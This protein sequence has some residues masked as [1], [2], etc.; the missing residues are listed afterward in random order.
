MMEWCG[1]RVEWEQLHPAFQRL[2]GFT[3]HGPELCLELHVHPIFPTTEEI[4]IIT[5]KINDL[6][7]ALK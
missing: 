4:E 2:F 1:R 6:E 3:V 7:E 5:K